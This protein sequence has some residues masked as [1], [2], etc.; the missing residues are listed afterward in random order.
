[1]TYPRKSLVSIK[2]TPYYHCVAR[3]VRRAW[4]WGVD[5]YAGKD[6]SHRKQWVVDRLREL[7]AICGDQRGA[8][9]QHLPPILKRLNIDANAWQ[10]AMQPN[11]NVFGRAMGQLNHLQLHAKALGQQWIKGLRQAERMYRTA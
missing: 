2:E 3:C 9:D 4:L 7:S 6:Y 1:M 10:E 8:I 5:E 11:G